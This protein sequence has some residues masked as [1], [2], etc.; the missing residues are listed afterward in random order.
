MLCEICNKSESKYKCPKCSCKYCSLSCFKSDVHKLKDENISEPEETAA[1]PQADSLTSLE[2]EDPMIV[3]LLKDTKFLE[4]INSPVL[5][6]H[7]LTILEI[8]NNISLTNEYSKDGRIEIASKKMN[9]LRSSGIEQNEY[10][11]EFLSYLTTWLYS[12][13]QKE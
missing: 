5:Q 2:I 1:I 6:F 9:N 4:Y 13:K 3:E 7:I 12:Y 8:L 10:F 11:D